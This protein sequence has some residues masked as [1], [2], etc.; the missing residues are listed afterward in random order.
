MRFADDTAIKIQE[1]LHDK[2]NRL[3]DTGRK[4]EMEIDIDK[5][6][7]EYPGGMDHCGLF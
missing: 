3:S 7:W 2:V 6:Q 5:S 1:Q 4:Y